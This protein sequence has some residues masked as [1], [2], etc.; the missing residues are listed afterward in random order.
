MPRRFIDRAERNTNVTEMFGLELLFIFSPFNFSL[1][2]FLY[3][4]ISFS[5]FFSFFFY[6]FDLPLTNRKSQIVHK[7]LSSFFFS[8]TFSSRL[9]DEKFHFIFTFSWIVKKCTPVRLKNSEIF[10]STHSY[11]QITFIFVV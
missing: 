7:L 8:F 9:E 5:F 2:L 11:H 4:F 10:A 3:I 1:S 6:F